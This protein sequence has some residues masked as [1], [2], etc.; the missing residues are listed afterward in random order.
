MIILAFFQ[1]AGLCLTM[2]VYTYNKTCHFSLKMHNIRLAGRLGTGGR[3][4]NFPG[5]LLASGRRL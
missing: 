2:N 4:T 5:W 1:H 3:Y